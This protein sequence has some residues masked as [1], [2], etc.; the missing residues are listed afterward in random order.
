[1]LPCL[2]LTLLAQD[3]IP[4]KAPIQKV[5]LHPD[6]AWVTRVG[7][8]RLP[9]AGTHKVVLEA[10]PS[11]LRIEDLQVAA[12][13]PAG[14][15]LG[16][17]ALTS[18]V[19]V[20]TETPDW[21]RLEAER[22]ALREKR[23]G[24]E[25]Q[26][27]AAQQE[28]IFLKG[29]QAAHDK[30]LSA[31][32]TYGTPNAT[33]ILDFGKNLQTRMAELLTGERRR[34]RELEKLT[35]EDQRIAAEMQKRAN[36][37]R[38]APSR[39]TVELT[40]PQAGEAEVE[41]SYRTRSARWKPLYEARLAEDRSR[42]DLVLFASVTQTT[43]EGWAGVRLEISNARPS[44]SLAVPSFTRGETINWFKE[45]PPPPSPSLGFASAGRMKADKSLQNQMMAEAAAPPPPPA[46]RPAEEA[47]A[48]VI[49]EASGLAATFLVEG[50]KDVPSDGEP[51]R[52][53]VQSREL[54]PQLTVFASPRLDPTG[55]LLARF[56][57]PSGLPLFPG[58]PVLRFAGNQRLGE[59]PLVLPTAGQ[60]FALG[61]GPYKSIRVAFQKIDRKQEEVGTFAKERQWT[62]RERIELVNDGPEALEVEVQDR[63]LKSG[64]DQV[65]ISLPGDFTPGWTEPLPGVRSWKLKLGAKERKQV[66]L[67]LTIR[68]P[69]DG[70]ISGLDF[71]P[72][73]EL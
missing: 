29:L 12:K 43:G 17:L 55:Y 6:E 23:D 10:L 51:H 37:R 30:E 8:A 65:K 50:R 47:T 13:G 52:F 53:K 73:E 5:R 32:M 18:D 7:K 64:S 49:E 3:S 16:D 41:L 26:G 46:P 11:G 2:S 45:P 58:S 54:A 25:S 31:R 71:T 70:V 68:A 59:A 24:L 27:E 38:T 40:A 1:M 22:E 19:R 62:L 35:R 56:P 67:P 72:G 36:E 66:E 69:K 20:V 33:A 4:L 9:E 48:S 21:K 57:A 34:K 42:L 44:R 61:F 15:R 28:L 63:I 14:L 60:P 39:V